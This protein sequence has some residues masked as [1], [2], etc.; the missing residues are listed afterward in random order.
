MAVREMSSS[1]SS[2][3]CRK[4]SSFNRLFTKIPLT[5]YVRERVK[6]SVTFLTK[7]FEGKTYRTVY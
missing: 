7:L 4:C 1:S 2:I 3:V 5:F 6:N